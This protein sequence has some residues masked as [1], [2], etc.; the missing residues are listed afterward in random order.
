M[1]SK[2]LLLA[3]AIMMCG[4]EKPILGDVLDD[5]M[6]EEEV[7]VL[8]KKFTFTMKGDFTSATFKRAAGYLQADGRDMTDVW[9]LD[10]MNGEL[11]QQIHQGDNTADDFGKPVMQLAY[12]SHHVYFVAS[13]GTAPTL[14]VGEHSIVWEKPSDTFWKDYEVNVV[15]TSNGNRA[16]TLDRVATKLRIAVDDEIPD[17]A[18]MM[19]ITPSTWYYGMDYTTGA[20]VA[21]SGASRTVDIPNSLHGTTGELAMTIFGLSGA[22][23]W[24]TDV[25]VVVYDANSVVLG[26]ASIVGAPFMRNR[27]TEYSGSLFSSGSL[28][29]LSLNEAWATSHIGTW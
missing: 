13:R 2:L 8:T 14:N 16:V 25:S 26:S 11:V 29:N 15:S 22:D 4:C 3:A 10:Y 19:T 17:N 6:D 7:E 20:A 21:S 12:G 27:S 18:A 9:V 23:E 1:K 28:T 24:T 5:E